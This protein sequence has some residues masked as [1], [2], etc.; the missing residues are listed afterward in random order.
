MPR[1]V[2]AGGAGEER[3]WRLDHG[4]G[5]QFFL[6]PSQCKRKGSLGV[7]LGHSEYQNRC[8]VAL[9]PI[10]VEWSATELGHTLNFCIIPTLCA[11]VA[12]DL[13]LVGLLQWMVLS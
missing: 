4:V 11:V 12:I 3:R 9:R 6:P 8:L 10:L 13:L 7:I 5:E 2:A 1:Y